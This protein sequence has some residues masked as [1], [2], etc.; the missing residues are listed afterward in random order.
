MVFI[1]VLRALERF[2]KFDFVEGL[3]TFLMVQL[4]VSKKLWLPFS[5]KYELG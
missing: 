4:F 2:R 5:K 3:K 1:D